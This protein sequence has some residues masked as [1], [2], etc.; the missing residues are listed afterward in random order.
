[1]FHM[2]EQKSHI[3][4]IDD[5]L[6]S[7][8]FFSYYIIRDYSESDEGTKE[9]FSEKPLTIKKEEKKNAI[10]NITRNWT[11]NY[12]RSNFCWIGIARSFRGIF[13]FQKYDCGSI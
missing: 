12:N 8:D 1:M 11:R 4:H 13:L 6:Y 3:L 7:Y 9:K 5:G 10:N 2:E